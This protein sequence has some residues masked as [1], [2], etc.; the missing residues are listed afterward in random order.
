M[1]RIVVSLPEKDNEFQLLQAVEARVVARRLGCTLELLYA[2]NS[3]IAQIQQLYN[4]IHADPAPDGVIVEPISISG[5][6]TVLRKAVSTG[7]GAAVLNSPAEYLPHLRSEYPKVP[8]LTVGSDQVE[9]GRLQGEQLKALLPQGGEVLVI[10]GPQG[11]P[12]ADERSRG[13]Q[14]S[15]EGAGFVLVE[16]DGRW[17][18]DSAQ[19]AVESWLRLKSSTSLRI[20]A[21]AAQ[22]DSMARG[23]RRATAGRNDTGTRWLDI[24]FLGI[25]GVPDMGQRLVDE[26]DLTATIV[27]PS[28]TGA[29]LE[30]LVLSLESGVLPPP[31]VRLRVAPYP[32][33]ERLRSRRGSPASSKPPGPPYPTV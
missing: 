9:I 5:V 24:P 33:L 12:A 19:Q 29:A 10:R 20:D 17:T 27:M 15:L 4:T 16:L 2:G 23:A 21:V 6:E 11:A 3:G 13:L 32:T 31:S 30:H 26:G 1:T 18:E 22:D 14:R 8:L 28:N 25:D 7:I